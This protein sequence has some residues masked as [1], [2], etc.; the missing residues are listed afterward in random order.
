MSF[1]TSWL[2]SPPPDAAIEIAAGRLSAAT[3][4]LRGGPRLTAHAVEALPAGAIVPS[5]TS[6]NVIDRETVAARLRALVHTLGTRVSRVAL[7]L[8]DASA[9]V[10]LVHFDRVPSKR[11]DLDQLVRWQL[12]KSAPFAI[13]DAC[14]SYTQASR[15]TDRGTEFLVVLAHRSVVEGYERVCADAGMYAGLIDIASLS[16]LNLLLATNP[17]S[18]DWLMVYMRPEETSIAIVRGGSVIF[19]RNRPESDQDTLTDLVHQTTMYY[20]DRLAGQGFVRVMLGG[21][22]RTLQALDEARHSLAERLGSRV[23]PIDPTE[24]APLSDRVGVSPELL[25]ALTPVTGL[26]LRTHREVV[27]A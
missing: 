5:L 13:D 15:V 26:L 8:P 7:V 17:P 20:Q 3:M 14:V 9:K 23:E 4:G 12:R 2:S 24:A 19:F 21:S 1:L 27:T 18:G 10:S 16:V 25:D 22:G 11:D 6:D